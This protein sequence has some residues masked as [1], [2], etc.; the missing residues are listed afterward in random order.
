MKEID[1]DWNLHEMTEAYPEL[2][3]ILKEMGFAGVANPVT[4]NTLGRLTTLPE[5]CKRQGKDFDEVLA[6]LRERGYEVKS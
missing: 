6:Q 2:I 1:L 3:P 5:G 4:R